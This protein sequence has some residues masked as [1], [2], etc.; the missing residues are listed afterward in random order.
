MG[1]HEVIRETQRLGGVSIASHVD[2][3]SYSVLG[4]LGFIP[5]DLELDGLEV[6]RNGSPETLF[7]SVP[8][9]EKRAMGLVTSSDAH[10]LEDIGA[11]TTWFTLES[12]RIEELRLAL[13]GEQGRRVEI[14]T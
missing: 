14:P 8:G 5:E 9:L 1:L 2:R 4:Q 10:E 6:S 7:E 12:P 13:R 3:P 11:A